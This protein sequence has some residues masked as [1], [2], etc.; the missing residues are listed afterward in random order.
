MSTASAEKKARTRR[1]A[2]GQAAGTPSV[3]RTRASLRAEAQKQRL[4]SELKVENEFVVQDVDSNGDSAIKDQS[5]GSE[6]SK[7]P[8]N[9]K[10]RCTKKGRNKERVKEEIDGLGNEGRVEVMDT[11]SNGDLVLDDGSASVEEGETE[12]TDFP[13]NRKGRC[14][15]SSKVELDNDSDNNFLGDPIPDDE[16]REKWPHRYQKKATGS[17]SASKIGDDEDLK[18]RCHFSQAEID[19]IVY[20]LGDC[21]Y[22]KNDDGED[23]FICRIV[24]FFESS[25]RQLYFS[26]RW[27]YRAKDTVIKDSDCSHDP[28]RVFL[29][30]DK[31]D[32]PLECIVSK[33]KVVRVAPNIDL[34]EKEQNIPECDLYYDMSY[35]TSYTSFANLP[36]DGLH[37]PMSSVTSDS[38][39]SPSTEKT[40][41][42][43]L[44]LY[45]GCGAMSTGLCLGANF[46]STNLQTRWAVDLNSFACESIKLNHPHTEVRNEDAENF[47]MLLQE[48]EKLCKRFSLIGTQSYFDDGCMLNDDDEDDL[49]DS[50]E[51]PKGEF[52]V[53]KIVG[54]CYGDPAKLSKVGLHF[55]VRWKG[56]GPSEDTWEPLD[57]LRKCQERIKDFVTSGYKRNILP[58]PGSADVICGGPPCQGISGFNRFRQSDAP[59]QDPKNKQVVVFMDIVEFLKPKYILMENVVDLLKFARGFLGRYAISRLVSMNYQSRMGLMV[60]GCYGLPQFRMRV[61]LWGAL[62]TEVLPQFPYP[63]HDVVIRGGCPNEFESNVVAY[64]ESQRPTLEKALLLGDAIR[65]L[66]PITNAEKRD[67]MPYGQPPITNFQQMI[68]LTRDELTGSCQVGAKSSKKACLFDHRPLELNDDDYQRVCAIPKRKGANFRDLT[69]VIVGED[70]VVEWDPEIPRV[71]LPSGKPLVPDYCM[72][73]IKGKS[74]K[75]F[76]RLWWDETVPTVVTRAEPHNQVILHP[77]QDRVLSI[78]ENARL[79]GF[80]DYYQLRGPIKERYI[81]VGNAVAVP[82]SR[83]LGIA[84]ARAVVKDCGGGPLFELPPGFQQHEL[85]SLNNLDSIEAVAETK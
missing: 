3:K 35:S 39:A 83:A 1:M 32:N 25:N 72:S 74:P 46:A 50:S 30:E 61:F 6:A 10:R 26:A 14:I 18:A 48:W 65:D 38:E 63:T 45:S 82:V 40:R 70:N 68:R 76:G 55:K 80:P 75:P 29:S 11:D 20:N 54:I 59:L 5:V 47:L 71:Y 84:L 24:E 21:A 51:V 31:N 53:G 2:A 7:L 8:G 56:Y 28:R 17:W 9:G 69:G 16:A 52:E 78:R 49:E 13:V 79:Q 66:P 27:F 64:D 33:I 44:D 58:L 23:N 73:F 77:E 67:E 43:L 36:T 85:T 41:L 62:P 19:G 60:A 81:Q 12:A 34:H 15:K 4:A 37:S 22:V 57:G 42:T